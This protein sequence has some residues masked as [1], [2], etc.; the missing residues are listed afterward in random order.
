MR[1][2]DAHET[3]R[4]KTI[5]G[6]TIGIRRSRPFVPIRKRNKCALGLSILSVIL[7]TRFGVAAPLWRQ[8]SRPTANNLHGVAFGNGLFVAVGDFGTLLRST[9]ATNWTTSSYA[10]T[11]NSLNGI[12][13]E[14]GVFVAIGDNGWT[15]TTLD[16]VHWA[17][18]NS[19]ATTTCTASFLPRASL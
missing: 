19:G 6:I 17:S 9:D 12:A 16:G 2:L 5:M 4:S 3:C 14:G 15:V 13:Y 11:G 7:I 1:R 8:V 10:G 18:A